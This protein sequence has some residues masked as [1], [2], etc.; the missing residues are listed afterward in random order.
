MSH[1]RRCFHAVIVESSGNSEKAQ[2]Y[3]IV[4]LTAPCINA[5]IFTPLQTQLAGEGFRSLAL[6]SAK[7]LA[8]AST[9]EEMDKALEKAIQDGVKHMEAA[10]ILLGHSL[11]C[12]SM[13]RYLESH[14]AKACVLLSPWTDPR[15][16]T[17]LISNLND[18]LKRS[19]QPHLQKQDVESLWRRY[20]VEMPPLVESADRTGF[21]LLTVGMDG[22]P[23][24][25]SHTQFGDRYGGAL[26]KQPQSAELG[27]GHVEMP[28]KGAFLAPL[29]KSWVLEEVR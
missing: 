28:Q 9:A 10:P 27:D 4:M 12:F 19:G 8:A 2:P 21:P 24:F 14:P 26:W 7:A 11:A 25:A 15:P 6:D 5:R 16:S 3:P 18:G 1:Q 23:F 17:S 13:L 22:D 20:V 29:I